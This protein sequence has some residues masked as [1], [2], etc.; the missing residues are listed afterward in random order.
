MGAVFTK[1]IN[2][3]FFKTWTSEMSYVLGYIT[4]DG[5]IGVD[6][7]RKKNPFIFNITS[8][9]KMHLYRIRKALSSQHKVSKKLSGNKRNVAFQLQIRNPIITNDLVSLG[10]LPRKTYNLGP[11]TIPDQYFSD[12]IRGFFDGDGSVYIYTV[13]N[14]SQIKTS[15][16]SASLPFLTDINE[17]ICR[18]LG[19]PQK[20]IHEQKSAWRMTKYTLDFYIEDSEK[21]ANFMYSDNVCLFLPRKRRVFEQWKSTKR[22]HYGKQNYPSKIGWRLNQKVLV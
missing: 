10:I 19:I 18:I 3:E 12:F 11:L 20:T 14:T 22:R 1:Y 6:K 9:E 8:A 5:C 16:L 17:R 15:F 21:L 13:N 4:A 7:S 2:Q